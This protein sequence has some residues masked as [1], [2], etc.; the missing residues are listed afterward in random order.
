MVLKK[1]PLDRELCPRYDGV[2]LEGF[3]S[4]TTSGALLTTEYFTQD[5]HV[6]CGVGS[7]I[8]RRTFARPYD[9]ALFEIERRK[10]EVERGDQTRIRQLARS[11]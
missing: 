2:T 6:A 3:V 9:I 10:S 7:E 1:S 11:P 4:P 8:R 5:S